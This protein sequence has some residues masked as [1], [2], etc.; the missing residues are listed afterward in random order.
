MSASSG[1]L[2]C[3]CFLDSGR[4]LRLTCLRKMW[5]C[6]LLLLQTPDIEVLERMESSVA[7]HHPYLLVLTVCAYLVNIS[8]RNTASLHFLSLS[9]VLQVLECKCDDRTLSCVLRFGGMSQYPREQKEVGKARASING[10]TP[11]NGLR[12]LALS[13]NMGSS[14]QTVQR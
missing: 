14:L 13:L 9:L 8:R 4:R 11:W 5:L 10:H 2:H 3:I 12:P 7:C 6:P 1:S